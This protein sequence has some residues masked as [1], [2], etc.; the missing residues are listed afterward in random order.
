MSFLDGNGLTLFKFN[1]ENG[2]GDYA[3]DDGSN[4]VFELMGKKEN[5]HFEF[6]GYDKTMEGENIINYATAIQESQALNHENADLKP[7]P[8]KEGTETHCNLA[9]QNILKTL[10][11]T[12]IKGIS[13]KGSANDMY[14][15]INSHDLFKNVS[16]EEANSNA[17]SGGLSI[18]SISQKGHGHIGSFSVG[19][20]INKGIYANIG[21]NK[22][23]AFV[24]SIGNRNFKYFILTLP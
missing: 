1:R 17:K 19:V 7:H 22:D 14:K 15:A 9:T 12:G 16:K 6:T 13:L 10:E 5:Q 24:N 11:S 2:E 4:A 3:V 18:F 8:S 21:S 20:N 23:N